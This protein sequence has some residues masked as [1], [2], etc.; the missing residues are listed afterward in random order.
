MFQFAKK[1][2]DSHLLC[3]HAGT[4]YMYTALGHVHKIRIHKIQIT[5]TM[6][7]IRDQK[8]TQY[9][10]DGGV[11]DIIMALHWII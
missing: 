9:E 2:M 6:P 1:M 8:P 5:T 4:K 11:Q 7:S 10:W 3:K